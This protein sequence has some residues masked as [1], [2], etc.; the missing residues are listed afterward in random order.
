MFDHGNSVGAAFVLL[1]AG[2]G[3]NLGL[4]VWAWQ[5]WGGRGAAVWLA[6]FFGT[7]LTIAAAIER[8]LSF[9]DSPPEDHTHAFD[10]FCMPFPLNEAKPVERVAALLADRVPRH[11]WM[12][13]GLLGAIVAAGLTLRWLDPRETLE[14]RLGEAA[15]SGAARSSAGRVDVAVPAPVLGGVL[16]AGLVSA[17]VAAAYLYYPDLS[18][19]LKDLSFVEAETHSAALAGDKRR[20]QVWIM[21]WEDLVRRTEVGLWIR[22]GNVT[23][24]MTAAAEELRERIEALEHAVLDP[25]TIDREAVAAEM[26]RVLAAG[27]AHRDALRGEPSG[28]AT[29]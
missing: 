15:P 21:A 8:P 9:R 29:D 5:A 2:A 28:A 4:V 1:A 19:C 20:T 13:L 22:R 3:L 25:E 26:K 24:E 18:T 14:A 23:K 11:E 7:V 27:R 10:V 12:A 16:V 6:L 17:S